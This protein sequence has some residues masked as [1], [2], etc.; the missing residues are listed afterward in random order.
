MTT[1]EYLIKITNRVSPV[2]DE[3]FIK[4]AKAAA[5]F[6]TDRSVRVGAVIVDS[7]R[8]VRATGY[9][10]FPRMVD[11]SCSLRHERPTKYRYTEHAERNAIYAAARRGISTDGCT[12]YCTHAPC[13]D[14]TRGIIQSGIVRVVYPSGAIIP[15]FV[16]DWDISLTMLTEAHIEIVTIPE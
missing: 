3:H 2:L 16:A 9:N 14:C 13:T 12:L 10:C 4:I 8:T 6:S 1:D 7:S 5:A 15:T 11:D